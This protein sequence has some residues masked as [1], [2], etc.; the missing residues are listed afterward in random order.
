V[1]SALNMCCFREEAHFLSAVQEWYDN[2][3]KEVPLV[4]VGEILIAC[5]LHLKNYVSEK[6]LTM[7]L[8]CG[9]DK[10]TRIKIEYIRNLEQIIQKEN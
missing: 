2:G 6:I 8:R 9:L 3:C 10:Y 7:I 5:I 1:F 4:K